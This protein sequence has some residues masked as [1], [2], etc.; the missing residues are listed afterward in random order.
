MSHSCNS[1]LDL[2]YTY[3]VIPYLIAITFHI[4]ISYLHLICMSSGN[5]STTAASFAAI[6]R[7]MQNVSQNLV[8]PVAAGQITV[9]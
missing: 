3:M 8:T 9:C 1:H 2:S 4:I 6:N 5:L 7:K